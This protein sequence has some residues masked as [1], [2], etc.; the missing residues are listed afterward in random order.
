MS[1][2]E[3]KALVADYSFDL[4]AGN[5]LI[6][7][8]SNIAEYQH[9][10]DTK[11]PSIRVI[12]SKQRLKNGSLCNIAPTH[13]IVFSN[14]EYEKVLSNSFHCFEVQ[15]RPENGKLVPFTGTE[16]VI[17]S[18]NFRKLINWK[19][20]TNNNQFH[21]TLQEINVNKVVGGPEL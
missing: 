20:T 11:V 4:F 18:L 10:V 9:I 2:G 21:H 1:D 5:Q 15:L 6:F 17:L 8:Y 16:K 13:R 7:V 14:L 12:D 3:A 19:H